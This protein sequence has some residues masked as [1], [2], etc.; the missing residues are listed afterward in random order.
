MSSCVSC[1]ASK[2]SPATVRSRLSL[3]ARSAHLSAPF[4]AGLIN[5]G[6]H[7]WSAAVWHRRCFLLPILRPRS[8][9]PRHGHAVHPDL[10]NLLVEETEIA[11][12]LG[13]FRDRVGI[14]PDEIAEQLIPHFHRVVA[15]L[16]LVRAASDR[17]ARYEKI[18]SHILGRDVIAGR[19]P[20]LEQE[21]GAPGLGNDLTS[22][23]YLHRARGVE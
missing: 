5:S 21:P 17:L 3:K 6:P 19:Q 22:D 20:R 1:C 13:A 15:G 2:P 11:F 9:R 4:N 10:V 23:D 7:D 8:D 18:H 12:D 14:G 16:A